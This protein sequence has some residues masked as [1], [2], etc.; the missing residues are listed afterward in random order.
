MNIKKIIIHNFY[1]FRDAELDLH[2]Y[3]GITLI[4]G[5][6]KDSKG[7]NGSGKSAIFEAIYFGLTGKTMRRSTEEGIVNNQDGKGC[8]VELHLN[9]GI[10][11]RRQKRPTK[12]ELIINGKNCNKDNAIATQEEIDR[13]LNTNY[14]ILAA[15]MFFGQSN[16]LS[17]LDASAED[18]RTIIRGFL[19]LDDIFEYR[20]RIKDY[21]SD[22]Y[23]SS[24]GKVS[25]IDSIKQAKLDIEK[26]LLIIRE[27]KDKFGDTFLDC[28]NLSLEDII[29]HENLNKSLTEELAKLLIEELVLCTK[30]LTLDTLIGRYVASGPRSYEDTCRD[31]GHTKVTVDTEEDLKKWEEDRIPLSSDL[32]KLKPKILEIKSNIVEPKVNSKDFSEFLKYKELCKEEDTYDTL[33]KDFDDKIKS[34]NIDRAI[35]DKRYEVMRFWEKAFSEQ[36]VIKYIVKNILVYLNEK[37]NYYLSFLSNSK[38]FLTFDEELNEKIVTGGREALYISLSGGEKRKVNLAVML[39]LRDLLVFTDKDKTN[40]ILFDEVAENLDDDGVYGLYLLLDNIKNS[41]NVFIITHNKHLESLLDSSKK[42]NVVKK[43]GISKIVR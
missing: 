7:S 34:Y 26:K 32:E 42:I 19:N 5:Q 4:R 38:Y 11:I 40:I 6:N 18:K 29:C 35:F 8:M 14:K 9:D 16:D 3:T 13:L 28:K 27:S 15:S 41:R 24:K 23:N 39:A 36:G 43:N 17:F 31:C 20:D 21:K 22:F 30:I 33:I 37:I 2:R 25:A 12:L 1:S 10:V